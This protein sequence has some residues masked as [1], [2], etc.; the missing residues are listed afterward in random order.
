MAEQ[1]H[2]TR[3]ALLMMASMLAFT[4]NDAFMKSLSGEVALFQSIFLRGLAT[5][6]LMGGIAWATG[7]LSVS[8]G[9]SDRRLILLRALADAAAAF[10]FVSALFN[11]PFAN[12]S[13]ILQALP[14]TVTLAGAVFL[15]EPVGWRRM[16]AILIGFVG[17]LLIVKPGAAS[18]NIYSIYAV[19]AVVVVTMRDLIARRL[20]SSVPSMTAALVNAVVV[21]VLAGMLAIGEDW[22]QVS[23]SQSLR[24][25]AAALFIIGAYLFS[26]MTMRVGE[27]GF[28]SPFRY[29]S[30]LVAMLL[31]FLVFGEW[32]DSL[33][34]IGATIVVATGV[35]TLYR[36]RQMSKAVGPVPLRAK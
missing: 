23:V 16:V 30:L 32:P 33:T 25:S 20:S 21:T 9:R 2:N 34:L 29:T 6:I 19:L 14:L 17:V 4:V 1:S 28:V 5:C 26:V 3:G 15:R 11:M 10:F 12:L 8:I 31:G 24:L 35:F 27:I 7:A 18:F 36:E 13:A 22:V